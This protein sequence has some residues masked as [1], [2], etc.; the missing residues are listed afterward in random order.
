MKPEI[1][2]I[3]R[4][5]NEE[6]FIGQVLK[7]VFSQDINKPFEVIVV[8]S[9]SNDATL[10]IARK[11]PVKILRMS[12]DRFSFGRA[13][14]AGINNAE[15][16][17]IVFLSAHALPQDTQWLN[18]LVSGV[19]G[20]IVACF[21]CQR[22]HEDADP[23]TTRFINHTWTKSEMEKNPEKLWLKF[24]NTNAAISKK[25]WER[26]K[27]N[28]E[29]KAGEDTEWIKRV[30]T[31]GYQ[32]AYASRASVSHS[33]TDTLLTMYSRYLHEA[34]ARIQLTHKGARLE[35][36]RDV[37]HNF[38]DDCRYVYNNAISPRWYLRSLINNNVKMAGALHASLSAK[39]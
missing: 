16:S 17:I 20:N 39:K 3:I 12:R 4:T 33:H 38:V 7:K 10:S 27:F 19:G 1:S 34:R 2:I 23:L 6:K 14:N 24:S 8:D 29:M 32:V 28:E 9:G 36:F 35:L 26:E 22:P 18:S 25:I 21:G 37:I 15:G 30:I 31:K 13:L 5:Y 11:N